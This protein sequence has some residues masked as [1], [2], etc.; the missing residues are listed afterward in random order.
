VSAQEVPTGSKVLSD[1]EN[2]ATVRIVRKGET[3]SEIAHEVYGSADI[4]VLSLIQAANSQITDIDFVLEKESLVLPRLKVGSMVFKLDQDRYMAF[5]GATRYPWRAEE[6]QKQLKV[7]GI[8][9][10]IVPVWLTGKVKIYRLQAEGFHSRSSAAESLQA[11]M[12]VE[13]R[14]KSMG[15]TL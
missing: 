5:V 14:A 10:N 8:S 6:W 12:P 13:F 3:I 7:K 2:L 11:I 9:V 1:S 15:E 4:Y